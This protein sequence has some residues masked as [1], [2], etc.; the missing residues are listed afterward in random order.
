MDQ[1]PLAVFRERNMYSDRLGCYRVGE[2][3]TYSKLEAIDLHSRTGTLPEWDFNRLKFESIDWTIEPQEDILELYKRRAQ[4]LRDKYDYIVL[5]WSAGADSNTALESF[6]LN[7]IHI[8]EI[9]T[10]CNYDTTGDK[11]NILNAEVFHNVIPGA[12]RIKEKY[13]HVKHRMFTI[14]E[15]MINF[16]KNPN[17]R[18]EWIF[19][20]NNVY[21]PNHH[22]RD[23]ILS[24]VPEWDALVQSGK[25]VCFL[26]GHEK[27]RLAHIDGKFR[28][29]FLDII[30]NGPDVDSI[31][32]RTPYTD[33]LF[34]WTADMPEIPIKQGHLV[35]NYLKR[36]TLEDPNIST[37]SNGLAYIVKDG[38]KLWITKHGLQSI[39][40][41]NWN[42]NTFQVTKGDIIMSIRDT[43]FF[44]MGP[45]NEAVNVYNIGLKEVFENLVPTYWRNHPTNIRKGLKC[46]INEYELE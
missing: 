20:R 30:D 18:H 3:R 14:G 9:V 38:Q 21:T 36:A 43:W 29:R 27:P 15:H 19:K 35:M 39:I 28:F 7:G 4:Q 46:F 6:L 24:K 8:D 22:A 44:Q 41:P 23:N 13:P 11:N 25:K 26:W 34:Y 2:F 42:N 37:E 33:E 16:F 12:E 45:D 31:S 1:S 32:G 5:W 17:M 10:Y 40:Y